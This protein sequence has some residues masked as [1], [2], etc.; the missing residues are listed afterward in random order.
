[1]KQVNWGV[2]ITANIGKNVVVPA[3][4]SA[5]NCNLYAIGSRNIDR[6]RQFQKDF[7]FEKAYGSYEELLEDDEIQAIYIP[8]PNKL[9]GEWI[10]KA[11]KSGKHILCEKPIVGTKK[12]LI[13]VLQVCKENKIILMEAFAY[14][15][16]PIIE[17]IKETLK[18]GEIGEISFIE[19]TFLTPR[20]KEDNIR[21]NKELLG[22][23]LYDL[24]CYPISLVLHLLE[25]EPI[26]VK[27]IANFTDSGIDDYANIYLEFANNIRANLL[28][29]MCSAKRGDRTYMVQKELLKHQFHLMPM[30]TCPI[31]LLRIGKDLNER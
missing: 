23:A 15:H 26:N 27:G 22:G 3:M 5:D 28:C 14:L 21:L 11:A 8:L 30:V 16:N 24:G 17:D 25:E 9:H 10:K 18:K 29:G 12:E 19:A 31:I 20:P 13:E 6:A 4:L 1:M 2:L 7:A